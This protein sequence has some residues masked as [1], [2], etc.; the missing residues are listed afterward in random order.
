MQSMVEI[1]FQNTEVPV[2]KYHREAAFPLTAH[3]TFTSTLYHNSEKFA[4]KPM[5][6]KINYFQSKKNSFIHK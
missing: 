5:S 1:A 6:G 3:N 2:A 4:R